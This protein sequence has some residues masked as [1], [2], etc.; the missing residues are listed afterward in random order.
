FVT[1]IALRRSLFSLDVMQI[2]QNTGSGFVWDSDGHIVTN[3]HVVEG[4][5]AFSVTLADQTTLDADVVGV[6]QDNDLAVLQVKAPKE[7]LPPIDIGSSGSLVVGQTVM[8]VGNPFGLDHTL[9]V[10]V[11]S[12]LG[13]EL[14]APNGRTIHDVIQT[15]AAINPGN[16]GGPLLDS[17]GRVVGI[18]SAIYSPSGVSAGIGF[19]VPI[20]TIK[21]LV[22][23]IIQYGKPIRPGVGI[24]VLPDSA[25]QRLGLQGVVIRD[26]T[27]DGPADRAGLVGLRRDRSGRIL[28]GDVIVAIDGDPVQDMDDLMHAFETR[29]VGAD[30]TVTVERDGQRRDVRMK[31]VAL[32]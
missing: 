11:V 32:E 23:Q 22:P 29:G 31:L 25:T 17:S 4:G 26:V 13:R 21:R 2:P 7:K 30:V 5:R 16:S 12:A 10:G 24:H 19:A 18:N 28:L 9:T 27:P 8:A 14:E 1:T 20:D 3:F 6:S 15:D